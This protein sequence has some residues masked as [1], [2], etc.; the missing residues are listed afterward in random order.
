MG[1]FLK[2]FF[3]F[4]IFTGVIYLCVLIIAGDTIPEQYLRNLKYIRATGG[5]NLTRLQEVKETKNVDILFIG[6][7]HAYR[8]FDVRIFE[9]ENI[10]SFNLGSSAQSPLQSEILLKRYLK[11]LNPKLL[12]MEVYPET[13][14]MDGIEASLDMISNDRNDAYSIELA[15]KQNHMKVYN[16]LFYSFY[17][18]MIW[19]DLQYKEPT[20]KNKDV[21]VHGGY[22]V[23]DMKHFEVKNVNFQQKEFKWNQSQFD[24]FERLINSLKE[25]KIPY[26]LVQAPVTKKLYSSYKNVAEFDK[27]MEAFGPYINFNSKGLLLNDSLHFYDKDHLNQKGVDI[28]NESLLKEIKNR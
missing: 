21:Y 11:N 1:K 22:V 27:R 23:R 9:K 5:H 25:R 26:L 20:R 8:G 7:S 16:T 13:F 6:S 17:R 19:N 4:F 10:R 28:F 15:K 2:T 18:Q 14:E 3:F 24:A 12:V